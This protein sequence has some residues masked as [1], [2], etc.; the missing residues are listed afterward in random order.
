MC[1][2][3]WPNK[4]QMNKTSTKQLFDNINPTK[5]WL[6]WGLLKIR[7]KFDH[8]KVQ[9]FIGLG[10]GIYFWNSYLLLNIYHILNLYKTFWNE[11]ILKNILNFHVNLRT[12]SSL[13]FKIPLSYVWCI[14]I[15]FHHYVYILSKLT[16]LIHIFNISHWWFYHMFITFE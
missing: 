12:Q 8:S 3:K 16:I 6:K 10:F 4:V 5:K 15:E 14:F 13:H 9:S 7:S 2:D 1:G 11:M